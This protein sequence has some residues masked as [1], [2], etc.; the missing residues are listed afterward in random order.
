MLHEDKKEGSRGAGASLGNYYLHRE[1]K[2]VKMLLPLSFPGLGSDQGQ[3]ASRKWQLL[4][5]SSILSHTQGCWSGS[6][7]E[8]RGQGLTLQADQVP[9]REELAQSSTP[10]GVLKF[11]ELSH[12][13]G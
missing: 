5:A 7:E 3:A 1:I 11:Q 6:Q 10:A 8:R 2:G 9:L 12:C 13:F 4:K